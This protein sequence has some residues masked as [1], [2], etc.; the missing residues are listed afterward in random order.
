[1]LAADGCWSG[2]SDFA[3]TLIAGK[4][5]DDKAFILVP[6]IQLLQAFVLLGE[7]TLHT[8]EEQQL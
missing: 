6:L 4:A 8:Q 3:L 1:M 7:A 5:Q 2:A